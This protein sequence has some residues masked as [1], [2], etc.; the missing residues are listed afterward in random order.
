[1]VVFCCVVSKN[2]FFPFFLGRWTSNLSHQKVL[3]PAQ[4]TFMGKSAQSSPYLFDELW[5]FALTFKE[6]FQNCVN[7]KEKSCC[8]NIV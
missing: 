1:M 4:Y 5:L 6:L 3:H 2:N 7:A 8:Q